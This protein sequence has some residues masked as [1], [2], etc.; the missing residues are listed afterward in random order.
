[1]KKILINRAP[2]S[3]PWGGGN[4]FVKALHAYAPKHGF[5]IAN[6]L[7]DD[8]DLIFMIDPRYDDMGIS[9][10][11]ISRYKELNPS[12]KV[13]Y[14][15]NE[16][17]KRKGD[18]DVIDPLVSHCSKVSD[19]CF[20]IS[21]WIYDY[22]TGK[23]WSCDRNYVV[24]S[25]TNTEHFTRREKI[26]NGKTNIV[27]HH[28]S[29]NRMKGSDVYEMLDK[30]VGKNDSYTF[31]YIG[32]TKSRFTNSKIVDSLF[33]LELG[34]ELSK[35]DVYVSASRFDPGPNHIIESLSCELP[36]YAHHDSGGAVEMVGNDHVYERFD[37]LVE[38]LGTVER[39]SS[40]MKINNWESCMNEYFEK[41][42]AIL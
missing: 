13:V 16:C 18:V 6:R 36:T 17:D 40:C 5:N 29:D 35:Y 25:G 26:P 24:Y 38:M 34:R 33:G 14:R 1:M 11:E 41:I 15:I 12:C 37:R 9:V 21:N 3:G 20:F 31:T 30:W 22:H 28:W 7:E 23:D 8:I 19:A 10:N 42:R 27:T 39:N 4:N 32:R 2:V